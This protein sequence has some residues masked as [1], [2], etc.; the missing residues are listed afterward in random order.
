M[1]ERMLGMFI[2]PV[3]ILYTGGIQ[4]DTA[5]Y[6]YDSLNRLVRADYG[7]GAYAE[8][9]Y[10]D[11]GNM[12]RRVFQEGP[13]FLVK[14][15][16]FRADMYDG[17]VLLTW[18]TLS[19]TDIAG[20]HILRSGSENGEYE[21]ITAVMTAAEGEATHGAVYSYTDC[22]VN[23]GGIYYYRLED[24]DFSGISRRS[25]A[26]STSGDAEIAGTGAC[27]CDVIRILQI[28]AGMPLSAP[29]GLT[30]TGVRQD[31]KAGTEDAVYL[32]QI[33]SGLR[34]RKEGE[35]KNE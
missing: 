9:S 16:E 32:L 35:E 20:F 7:D 1:K 24:I 14:L 30:D 34:D 17:C 10:D 33:V 2:L 12:T 29:E 8:Y 15:A 13:P 21:R 31:G 11:A 5:A 25:E 18:K 26:V 27:L 19:E 28:L 6:T 4:A 22:D 23:P 3:L